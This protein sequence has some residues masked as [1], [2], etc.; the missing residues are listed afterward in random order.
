MTHAG[1]VGRAG[2]RAGLKA[3]LF[4][5][6]VLAASPA[7]AE[8]PK[9]LKI[10]PLQAQRLGIEIVRPVPR[11]NPAVAELPARI[12]PSR[13]G[14]QAAVAAF[15]GAVTM[16]NVLPGQDVK[17]G[18][19]I[20]SISSRDF[21]ENAAALEAARSRLDLAEAAL[22]RSRQ[23][24]AEGLI[25]GASLQSM[26]AEARQARASLAMHQKFP[27]AAGQAGAYVLTAPAS[28]RV[29]S[30]DVRAGDMVEAMETVATIVSDSDVWAEIQLPAR[31]LG[32]V[33]PGDKVEF[34]PDLTGEILSVGGSIDPRT[35]SGVVTSTT[36]PGLHARINES[37]RVR[38]LAGGAA[39]GILEA[40]ATSV[41]AIEGQTTVFVA[42]RDGFR[43]VAVEVVGRSGDRVS[44]AAALPD[45]ASIASRGLTEL[46]AIV[47]AGEP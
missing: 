32:D 15:A 34:G 35:R 9:F 11:G 42:E 19:P 43:P 18:D 38:I 17:R 10:S 45:N 29:G 22:N 13:S 26:E 33:R 24:K 40:P 28:G 31:L 36:P 16:V 23:L 8:E 7:S 5:G 4:L 37:L 2:L 25:S 39:S 1:S 41:I 47:L 12:V 46:K 44:I 20:A 6:A 3:L 30:L 27:A 14:G 21:A